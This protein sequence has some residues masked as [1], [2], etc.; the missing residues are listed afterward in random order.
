MTDGGVDTNSYCY[1]TSE[2]RCCD[3]RESGTYQRNPIY[4][5][6]VDPFNNNNNDVV[7]NQ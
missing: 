5:W 2:E 7:W 4:A 6:W 1:D 3:K